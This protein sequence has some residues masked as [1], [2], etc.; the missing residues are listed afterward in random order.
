[1]AGARETV[2]YKTAKK[3]AGEDPIMHLAATVLL[4]AVQH[5]IVGD[6]DDRAWLCSRDGELYMDAI[7]IDPDACVRWIKDAVICQSS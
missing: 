6:L 1:M 5:A 2:I 7:G 4:D 3:F